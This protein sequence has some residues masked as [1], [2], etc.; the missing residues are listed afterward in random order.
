MTESPEARKLADAILGCDDIRYMRYREQFE[1]AQ[2]QIAKEVMAILNSERPIEPEGGKEPRMIENKYEREARIAADALRDALIAVEA[3]GA[4]E[5]LTKIVIRLSDDRTRLCNLF[6][7]DTV[8][9]FQA[10]GP[11]RAGEG[12]EVKVL[13]S[14]DY[15]VMLVIDPRGVLDIKCSVPKRRAAQW[16]REAAAVLDRQAEGEK[17]EPVCFCK[18]PQRAGVAHRS[19]ECLPIGP[20]P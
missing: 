3:C 9:A 1:R 13:D 6:G 10:P 17:P 8:Q 14:R 15:A 5:E 19:H 18:H 2:S 4:D 20:Q 11:G 7:L 12:D 16:L